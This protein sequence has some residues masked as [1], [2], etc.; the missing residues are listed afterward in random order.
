M[1]TIRNVDQR[2]DLDQRGPELH[3][4]EHLTEIM[5]MRQHDRKCDQRDGPLRQNPE[6]AP[7]VHVERDGGDVDDRC[8]GPVEE[9]HPARDVSRLLAEEFARVR[10]ERTRRRPVQHQFAERAQDEEDEHAADARTR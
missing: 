6:S 3:L 8:A 1:P 7:V 4:T 5:L 9:V 2:D 10:H